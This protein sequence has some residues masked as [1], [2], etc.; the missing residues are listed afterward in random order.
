MQ[1]QTLFSMLRTATG[2]PPRRAARLGY[3]KVCNLEDFAHP[4]VRRTIRTV[5]AHE[6]ARFGPNFPAG[7]EYRKHW[8]VAMA[9]RTFADHG[10]LRPD[11]AVLGVAAGN[12]PTVFWLTNHVGRVFATDLYLQEGNWGESANASM[13][14]AP[15]GHWPAAWNPRRLVVQHMNALELRYEDGSFDG[16]FSSSS[17]E[18]FG[19]ADEI[20]RAAG[21]MCRVLKPGGVLSLSTEFRIAGPPGIPGCVL[22]DETELRELIVGDLPWRPV[23]PLDLGVSEATRATE[24]PIAE[25]SEDVRRHV[26]EHGHLVFHRL[27]WSRYPHIVLRNGEHLFT[28]VHLA[29]RKSAAGR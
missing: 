18:H 20:R 6:L 25:A 23:S 29:L 16:I 4:D 21:E 17:I 26:A 2:L 1:I 7:V 9:A 14:V 8:E 3:N 5:F 24:Q 11:A 10:V 27:D 22:F 15:G 28:S 12:E 19:S 13:L